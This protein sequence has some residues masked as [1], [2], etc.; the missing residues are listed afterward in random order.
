MADL[1]QVDEKNDQ[2]YIAYQAWEEPQVL[3]GSADYQGR[4]F[5]ISFF[6]LWDQNGIR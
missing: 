6:D 5:D 1:A 3:W 2:K 4:W